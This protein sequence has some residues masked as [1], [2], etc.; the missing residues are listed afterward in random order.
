MDPEDV[1]AMSARDLLRAYD[2][3]VG[4]APVM[5]GEFPG[6]RASEIAVELGRRAGVNSYRIYE[7]MR[8]SWGSARKPAP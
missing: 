7:T 6:G 5:R 1:A 2:F 3:Y 4:I 8:Q